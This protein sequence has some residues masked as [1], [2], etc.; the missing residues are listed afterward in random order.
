MTGSA[1]AEG[2]E[3]KQ[4]FDLKMNKAEA[5]LNRVGSSADTGSSER[6]ADPV[7]RT[8]VKPGAEQSTFWESCNLLLKNYMREFAKVVS[9]HHRV[10]ADLSETS[11]HW[12]RSD[13]MAP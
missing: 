12:G 13:S 5:Q 10:R 2:A 4:A 8:Y 9:V 6:R 3:K 11:R 1:D 7:H